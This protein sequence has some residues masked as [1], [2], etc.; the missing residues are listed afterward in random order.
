MQHKLNNKMA[1]CVHLDQSLAI[2][3]IIDTDDKLK[4]KTLNFKKLQNIPRFAGVRYTIGSI[5]SRCSGKE[6]ALLGE[7]RRPDTRERRKSSLDIRYHINY[8]SINLTDPKVALTLNPRRKT[9]ERE[10]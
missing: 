9:S 2:L 10:T 7:G 8:Q 6:P 3:Q 1:K 4:L 5:T